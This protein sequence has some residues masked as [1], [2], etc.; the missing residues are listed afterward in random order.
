MDNVIMMN[1]LFQ[2][3]KCKRTKNSFAFRLVAYASNVLGAIILRHGS[4]CFD[5]GDMRSF[6]IKKNLSLYF[7]LTKKIGEKWAFRVAD[8]IENT[9]LLFGRGAMPNSRRSKLSD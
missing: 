3:L 6:L 8:S 1:R 7:W 2:G 9:I 5:L 4:I